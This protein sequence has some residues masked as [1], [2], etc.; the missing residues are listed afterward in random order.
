MSAGEGNT[1]GKQAVAG[2]ATEKQR[3]PYTC[4]ILQ[5]QHRA[6]YH[7]EYG[8]GLTALGEQSQLGRQADGAEEKQ[9]QQVAEREVEGDLRV[10]Q[11]I[12]Q[13]DQNAAQQAAG[14]CWW[15]VVALQRRDVRG[16]K[17]AEEDH[18]YG[19]AENIQ[20]FYLQRH[21]RVSFSCR[22]R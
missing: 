15:D 9:Q 20:T 10:P 11:K 7:H 1:A 22:R 17:T 16:E 8:D 18:Q 19:D 6:G 12:H 14:D 2:V 5:H 4:D 21:A 13:S 3:K